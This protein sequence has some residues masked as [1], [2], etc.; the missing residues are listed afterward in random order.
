VVVDRDVCSV[1]SNGR[2]IAKTL[3]HDHARRLN[4]ERLRYAQQ[5]CVPC[6]GSF[7]ARDQWGENVAPDCQS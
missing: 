7:R 1:Q 2:S 4:H 3:T 5:L 6:A